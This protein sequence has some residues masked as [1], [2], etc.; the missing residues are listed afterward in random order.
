MSPNPEK[1]K[2]QPKTNKTGANQKKR[3]LSHFYQKRAPPDIRQNERQPISKK[4]RAPSHIGTQW[5]AMEMQWNA[6]G[7]NGLPWI[8]MDSHGMQWN[9]MNCHG[10]PWIAMEFNG[11]QWN[12]MECNGMQWSAM[13][14]NGM[15]WN[16]MG[17]HRL[18]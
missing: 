10:L 1:K 5:N 11:M 18:P 13:E 17:F 16:A 4:K 6:L 7:C 12:A 3:A 15:Q 8:T 9:A 2:R 14:C